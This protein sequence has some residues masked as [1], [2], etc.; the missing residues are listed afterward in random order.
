[1]LMQQIKYFVAV[2]ECRS[3]TEAAERCFITQSAIS[4]QIKSLEQELGGVK[5][6]LREKRKF[7]L[8][9]AGE[10]FY[11]RC[12]VLLEDFRRLQQETLQVYRLSNRGLRVGFLS[13]FLGTQ[14]LEAAQLLLSRH[15]DISLD[16]TSGNQE[17]IGEMLHGDEI[18]LAFL[19]LRQLP[20]EEYAWR[21]IAR[22]RSEIA[23]PAERAL[24][25]AEPEELDAAALR[26]Q[27]CIILAARGG[28]AGEQRFYRHA[29][30]LADNFLT[31]KNLDD[32][33]LAVASRKGFL[34]VDFYNPAAS[35]YGN[36]L[37]ALPIAKNGA[38]L[39]R[40]Y[41]AVWK[42][43]RENAY[44]EEFVEILAA[45]FAEDISLSSSDTNAED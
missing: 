6:I 14:L 37:R 13:N 10:Y 38:P 11:R 16:F 29:W 45:R 24:A 15:Q 19:D 3:F 5:L 1:M 26:G 43:E 36:F 34:P 44:L 28:T 30:G 2:V 9:T 8:T 21:E 20:G 35:R 40:A 33:L 27:A 22:C 31:A 17:E 4:Q 32:A 23:L 41:A 39:A 18:D 12:V 25:Q 7:E 42:R